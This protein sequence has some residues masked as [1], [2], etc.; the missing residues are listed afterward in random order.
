MD[1]RDRD[2]IRLVYSVLA[3]LGEAPS[4]PFPDSVARPVERPAPTATLEDFYLSL[5]EAGANS[6]APPAPVDRNGAK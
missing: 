1:A 6:K 2:D 3:E 5:A 4:R